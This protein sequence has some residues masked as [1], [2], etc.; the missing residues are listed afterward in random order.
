MYTRPDVW[1]AVDGE[2]L[3]RLVTLFLG[4][5][6]LTTFPNSLAA[7]TACIADQISQQPQDQ[8]GPLTFDMLTAVQAQLLQQ[9]ARPAVAPAVAPEPAAAEPPVEDPAAAPTTP[10]PLTG[11]VMAPPTSGRV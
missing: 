4:D 11:G 6:K 7:L 9:A 10:A 8:W 2:T 5:L 1:T 3:D